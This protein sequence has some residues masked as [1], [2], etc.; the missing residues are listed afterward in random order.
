M[1]PATSPCP[2]T[3][4]G[5]VYATARM[6]TVQ[7]ALGTAKSTTTLSYGLALL[8]PEESAEQLVARAGGAHYRD[9][10]ERSRSG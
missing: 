1:P 8:G 10:L 2:L 3:G 5:L 4:L 7:A 9:R 6:K